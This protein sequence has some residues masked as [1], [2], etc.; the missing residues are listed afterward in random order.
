MVIQACLLQVD[1]H[2]EQRL[3]Y[4]DSI[5]Q[6]RDFL[7]KEKRK[8]GKLIQKRFCGG[9]S[10]VHACHSQANNSLRR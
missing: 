8:L 9:S 4:S 3:I 1:K 10:F 6:A 2:A 7:D 5:S